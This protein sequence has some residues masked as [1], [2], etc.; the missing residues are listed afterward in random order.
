MAEGHGEAGV[1]DRDLLVHDHLGEDVGTQ[2]AVLAGDL[3]R[4]QAE[5]GRPPEE[6]AWKRFRHIRTSVQLSRLGLELVVGEPP[7][8]LLQPELLVTEAEVHLSR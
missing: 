4:P 5:R 1:P 6:V 8:K 2:P 3:Q 7:R